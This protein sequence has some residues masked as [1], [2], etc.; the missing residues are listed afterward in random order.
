MSQTSNIANTYTDAT[1]AFSKS[2][3]TEL[4]A[5][6]LDK[7]IMLLAELTSTSEY[8]RRAYYWHKL[9]TLIDDT[10]DEINIPY[11]HTIKD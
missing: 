7:A 4:E 2:H 6:T 3:I 8:E 9:S 11:E 5:Y 1:S 10:V